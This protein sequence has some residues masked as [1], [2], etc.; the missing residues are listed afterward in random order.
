MWC[1][2][3]SSVVFWTITQFMFDVSDSNLCI[4]IYFHGIII[5][6]F[7]EKY[8]SFMHHVNFSRFWI[9]SCTQRTFALWNQ[10]VNWILICFYLHSEFPEFTICAKG[11]PWSIWAGLADWLWMLI[12]CISNLD[13]NTT[14][15]QEHHIII[16]QN[17]RISKVAD[18]HLI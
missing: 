17:E 5:L 12:C 13:R 8:G 14:S 18:E 9:I 2:S 3:T 15:L 11:D 7:T 6:F 1:L 10:S 4:N 16:S